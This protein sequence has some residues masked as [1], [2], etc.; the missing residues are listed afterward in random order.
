MRV[1]GAKL[2]LVAALFVGAF[3][4]R[5]QILA[6]DRPSAPEAEPAVQRAIERV[7]P[8]LV[9]IHVLSLAYTQGHERKQEAAGSGAIISPEGYVVTNHHVAGK[10]TTIRLILSSKEEV[11]GTLVGTDALADIAVIKIDLSKRAKDAP[12]LPV[13]KWG[14]AD[15]LKVGDPVLAMG[16][17][18][19]LSH[20][21]TKGIVA[22]KELMTARFIRSGPF[23]L[24][25]EDVG[26]IVKWIGHDATIQPGNSGGPLVNLDGEIIGINE[27]GLGTMSGA[28][29]SEIA[30]A[31]AQELIAHGKVTRSWVGID[32][33]P[34]LKSETNVP[35][36]LVSGVIP[37]SPAETA[38]VKPGDIVTA[39]DDQSVRARFR[40][41]LPLF[42]RIL[43]GKTVGKEIKL[44]L[45]RAGAEMSITVK[46]DARD[47]AEGK[48]AEERA[49]G[50]TAREI[51]TM[52]AKE[53]LRADKKGV[54]VGSVRQ[55]GPCDQAQ[56]A[57]RPGD[58]ILDVAGEPVENLDAFAKK[59]ATLLEGKTGVVPTL[60]GYERGTERLL[61]LVEVGTKKP[62]D[63]TPEAKKPWLGVDTQVLSKKL[64]Q[65]LG[66]KG[67]KGVRI[68]ALYPD[69][70]A[71]AAGLLVGDIVTHIDD[72]PI[73]AT[74]QRGAD[75]FD[76]MIRVYKVD[77]KAVFKVIRGKDT[78]DVTATLG[79]A[80]KPE[81]E[82]AEHEDTV[83]E[84]KTRDV[85]YFDRVRHRWK[86]DEAGALVTQ[87][88]QG[89]WASFGGIHPD[90]LIQQVAGKP[91][92]SVKDLIPILEEIEKSRPRT[93]SFLVKRGI[94]TLF[95]E[96]EPT[97]S[98]KSSAAPD[99]K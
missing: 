4:L 29:P 53:L 18:L 12:P 22:N 20:S 8:A 39:L 79:E 40:E 23:M 2:L 75:V 47:D 30:S 58:I 93:V 19:A 91:V 92:T 66:L 44:T 52:E 32:F 36:V 59:T 96:L 24:D 43:L 3:V 76:D 68:T 64:A 27:I 94:H 50:F 63:P 14:H 1:R 86:K 70:P 48:E 97:W 60:V 81:R 5:T 54:Y 99:T 87:L 84:L 67:K 57:I 45:V 85:S 49:W 83:L 34:L 78:M 28:I 73:E 89:G 61:T 21:V 74:E 71:E 7:Y 33:Q 35:G 13:A 17:P 25:G 38:G 37:G 16:C 46:S 41:E 10:A 31:V 69:S 51:T 55:G 90:D 62:Q 65:A 82:L 11:E 88:E 80:P 42:N 77:S 9:Q 15:L 26:S 6:E 56:P 95:V 98:V 72:Q